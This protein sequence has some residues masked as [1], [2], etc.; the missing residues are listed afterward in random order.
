MYRSGARLV[1]VQAVQLN[2]SKSEIIWFGTRATLK[3]LQN[4]DLHL[5]VE[6][7]SIAPSDVVCDLGGF[8]DSELTAATCG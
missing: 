8:L 3:H 4:T 6:I 1:L 7:D 2:L 5:H